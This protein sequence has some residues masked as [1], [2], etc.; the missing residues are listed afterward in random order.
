[1]AFEKYILPTGT[2]PK[3]PVHLF[4]SIVSEYAAGE[5]TKNNCLDAI[6]DYLD[7]TLTNDE[8][9]D[10]QDLMNAMDSETGYVD[11]MGVLLDMY[12]VLMCAESGVWYTTKALL[13]TRLSWTS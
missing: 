9:T 10:L 5:K 11:K 3:M 7:V 8:K 1:M 12:N 2:D 13:R 4:C 6:E